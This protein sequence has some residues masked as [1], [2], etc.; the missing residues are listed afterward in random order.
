MSR[1][2]APNNMTTVGA[3]RPHDGAR[4]A[5]AAQVLCI[6]RKRRRGEDAEAELVGLC[7]ACCASDDAATAEHGA[8]LIRPCHVN[9]AGGFGRSALIEASIRGHEKAV[10]LLLEKPSIDVNLADQHGRTA[11]RFACAEGHEAVVRLLLARPEIE[12][13][14]KTRAGSTPLWWAC[15]QGH[16]AIVR[17]LLERPELD[18]TTSH[19]AATQMSTLLYMCIK[20]SV[21]GV[22]LLLAHPSTDPNDTQDRLTALQAACRNGSAEVVR[23]LLAHP[24]TDPNADCP[25][26]AACHDGSE[27]VVRTLLAHPQTD[28]NAGHS[29]LLACHAGSAGIVQLM[30]AH[31]RI[32]VNGQSADGTTIMD[33][34]HTHAIEAMLRRA[35]AHDTEP[36]PE[37]LSDVAIGRL[38]AVACTVREAGGDC[39]VC[40]AAFDVGCALRRL[41]CGHLFHG[42]CIRSWLQRSTTCPVCRASA[43]SDAQ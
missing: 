13:Q 40:I 34:E 43:A 35:G 6:P 4:G 26:E 30:L 3:K 32:D 5:R 36:A 12:T 15:K 23:M 22:R 28:P 31:P 17:L 21:D 25:L 9:H 37:R 39:S 7:V 11:L 20:S 8:R 27:E 42:G 29:L 38:E 41:P 2:A 14:K 1:E 24:K 16:W 10:V 33:Y 18:V 19:P